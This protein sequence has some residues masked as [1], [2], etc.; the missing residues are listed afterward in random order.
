MFVFSHSEMCYDNS[1]LFMIL[2][3]F[4]KKK[5]LCGISCLSHT[6]AN[7]SLLLYPIVL[8]FNSQLHI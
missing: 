5:S 7:S 1:D 3:L 6:Q 8:G 2:N 4:L